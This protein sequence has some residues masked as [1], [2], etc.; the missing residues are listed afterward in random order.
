MTTK[1]IHDVKIELRGTIL[2]HGDEKAEAVL[3]RI[4]AFL[5]GPAMEEFKS[6]EPEWW[7]VARV[8]VVT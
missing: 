6:T 5:A 8:E 1:R 3:E 7:H 2:V 4:A